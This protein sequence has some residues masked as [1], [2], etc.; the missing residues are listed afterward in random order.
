MS[1]VTKKPAPAPKVV[2]KS[3]QST[4]AVASKTVEKATK[5]AFS[6]LETSHNS[7]KMSLI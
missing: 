2:M 3:A 4:A 6:T 5:A 1:Q 7:R